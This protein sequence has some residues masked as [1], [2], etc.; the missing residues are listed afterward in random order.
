MTR[1]MVLRRRRRRNEWLALAS[2]LLL[3][4]AVG[5]FTLRFPP[6]TWY[7]LIEKPPW[8]PPLLLLGSVA[9]LLYVLMAVAAWLVW[10]ERTHLLRLPALGLFALQLLLNG[11]WSYVFFGRQEIGWALVVLLAL[12]LLLAATVALFF[13]VSNLAGSVLVPYLAWISFAMAV[14]LEIWRL[15]QTLV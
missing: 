12:W 3:C 5:A 10:R 9:A 4:F 2:F 7:Q 11:V 1:T 6:G 15:N 8:T 13:R 14:N